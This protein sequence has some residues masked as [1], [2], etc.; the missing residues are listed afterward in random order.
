[1]ITP[2]AAGL[3]IAVA[4]GSLVQPASASS[5]GAPAFG[6]PV[7][8]QAASGFTEPRIVAAPDGTLVAIVKRRPSH[9]GASRRAS[10]RAA[11]DILVAVSRPAD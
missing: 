1:M 6:A 8:V 4:V 10:P 3:L 9:H 2:R 7:R 11:V 5:G